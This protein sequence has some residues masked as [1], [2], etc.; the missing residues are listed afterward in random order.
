MRFLPVVIIVTWHIGDTY[1]PMS[2]HLPLR[3]LDFM[4]IED[5]M[6]PDGVLFISTDQDIAF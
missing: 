1:N 3:Y 2:L 6:G 4:N 5:S